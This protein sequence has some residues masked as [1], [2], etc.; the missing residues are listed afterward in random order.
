MKA[1]LFIVLSAITFSSAAQIFNQEFYTE[2]GSKFLL[3]PIKI[4]RLTEGDYG[5]WFNESNTNYRVDE[6]YLPVLQNKLNEYEIR[7]FL[8]TWCGDS[9]REVPHMIKIMEAAGYPLEKVEIFAVDG[10][11]EFIKTTPD[12]EARQQNIVRVPTLIFLKN[13]EEVNRIIEKPVE[14]LEKDI[15]RIV[16]QKPY[17]PHYANMKISH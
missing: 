12:G 2:S 8:G 4:D 7:L 3:G 15:A 13:G 16:Q 10:R 9:K 5:V 14:N 6:S 1:I 17:T 11:K